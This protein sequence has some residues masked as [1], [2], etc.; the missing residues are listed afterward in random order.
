MDVVHGVRREVK[1]TEVRLGE[2]SN[3]A[4][5][6]PLAARFRPDVV[7]RNA[8]GFGLLRLGEGDDLKVAGLAKFSADRAAPARGTGHLAWGLHLST[9]CVRVINDFIGKGLGL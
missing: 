9:T 1:R 3:F 8:N 2:D 6:R 7:N 4:Q 5:T